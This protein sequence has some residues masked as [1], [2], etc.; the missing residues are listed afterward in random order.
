MTE[1]NNQI[2]F[3]KF[4]EYINNELKLSPNAGLAIS[5]V[6][7]KGALFKEGFGYR[8]VSNKKPFTTE[9]IFP[10]ASH[11]K[12]FT[13]TALAMLV[14]DGKIT[15]E[16]PIRD[17][18]SEF[19]LYDLFASER[20]NLR[21]LLSH[22]TGLPHH[23]FVYMNGEWN[24]KDVLK[25]LPHL[26]PVYGFRKQHKYSNLNFI[27]ATKLVEELSGKNYFDF[28][29][30]RIFKPLG[31]NNTNFS[32]TE[33]FKQENFTY[34][35]KETDNGYI[36]EEYLDLKM[37]SAGAGSINS[38]L[39]DLSKWIQFHLN[40]GKVSNKELIS[41]KT[42]NELYIMQKLDK[43]PLE[44]FFPEKNYV[45]NYGFALGW[46]TLNYRGVKMNQHYGTG[47]GI[48]FNGGFLRENNL[49]YI[50]FSNTSGSDLPFY[51]NFYLVDQLLGLD[52]AKWGDE[53]RE[54]VIKQNEAIAK[55]NLEESK[56]KKQE[57]MKPS[58]PLDDFIGV[59]QHPGYG[60]L[61]FS[62]KN[63][64]LLASYGKGSKVSIEH[65]NYDTFIIKIEHLGGFGVPKFVTFRADFHGKIS[66]LEI[67]A[68]PLREPTNFDKIK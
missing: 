35:Y 1:V 49:G 67:D 24:Y 45:Q 2:D 55:K 33:V 30:E 28:I 12:S 17:V 50:I 20:C 36:L 60:E 56:A 11:T 47:P 42:L 3:E 41:E 40:K 53:I 61:E 32:I 14:D 34:G 39:D 44:V 6:S 58:H 9:T 62:L 25:Q 23:Q 65:Y 46:W 68:E 21:D 8:D 38:N 31:M 29:T 10:I 64:Q 16:T 19:R 52:V 57:I 51:L 4:N 5:V 18:V 48:L 22:T 59:Y 15:W 63:N 37:G 43:N 13:A 54:F 26:K 66:H 7:D 27:T